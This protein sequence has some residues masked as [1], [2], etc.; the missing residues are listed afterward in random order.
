M[1]IKQGIILGA[2]LGLASSSIALAEPTALDLIKRGND[3]VGM[4][5]RDKVVQIYSE[6]SVAS[7][8]PNIW[9]VVYFDPTVMTRTVEVKF[10]AGQQTDV[11][12]PIHPFTLP[13]KPSQVIDLSKVTVDSDRAVDIATS[14]PLLKGLKLRYS[15]LTLQ[16]GD[17]G[18][19]WK[20]ELWSAKISDPTK[21]A[22]VGSV[23]ISAVDGSIIQSDL[24]PGN[25]G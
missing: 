1:K 17:S 20:V 8:E 13:A 16:K 19:E 23:R 4:E 7:L 10:E 21:D 25:A 14:Q 18:P 6:K 11:S 22:D 24:R 15:K 5:S 12:H 9:H 3:Y 2:V